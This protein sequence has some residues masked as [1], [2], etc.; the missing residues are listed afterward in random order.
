VAGP[1]DFWPQDSMSPG[2]S[3]RHRDH[4]RRQASAIQHPGQSM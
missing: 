1:G 2:R 3:A 4:A